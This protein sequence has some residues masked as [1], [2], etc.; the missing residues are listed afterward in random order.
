MLAQYRLPY[1]CF[2]VGDG[3]WLRDFTCVGAARGNRTDASIPYSYFSIRK[4]NTVDIGLPFT[5]ELNGHYVM[6]IGIPA[7]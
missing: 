7:K 3:F 2:G 6:E 5:Q 4:E 1:A